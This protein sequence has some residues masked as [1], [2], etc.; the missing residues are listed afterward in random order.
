MVGCRRTTRSRFSDPARSH[1]TGRRCLRSARRI[2]LSRCRRNSKGRISNCGL[3]IFTT[4]RFR[5]TR[6]HDETGA[7]TGDWQLVAGTACGGAAAVAGVAGNIPQMKVQQE[8]PLIAIVGPTASGKS[9]LAIALA[10]KLGA[11]V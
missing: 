3:R 1:W 2:R 4:R 6:K 9:A 5:K 10:E 7:R 11:E 8:L